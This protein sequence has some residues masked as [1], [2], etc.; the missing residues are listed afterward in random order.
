VKEEIV[1]TRRKFF[2]KIKERE[3]AKD[4]KRFGIPTD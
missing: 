4:L 2:Q 3:K 1:G